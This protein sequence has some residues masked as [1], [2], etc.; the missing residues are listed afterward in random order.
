MIEIEIIF[1]SQMM[2]ICAG[3]RT[4]ESL[5][6]QAFDVAVKRTKVRGDFRHFDSNCVEL[7][8][9]DMLMFFEALASLLSA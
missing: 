3:R 9:E 7:H 5:F 6:G 1:A 2:E 8:R 4:F